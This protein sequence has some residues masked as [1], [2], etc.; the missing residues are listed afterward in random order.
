[1]RHNT[2]GRA[3]AAYNASNSKHVL[4]LRE[5]EE[6]PKA[7]TSAVDTSSLHDLLWNGGLRR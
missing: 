4:K 1:M 2:S 6:D 7:K 3:P 5:V